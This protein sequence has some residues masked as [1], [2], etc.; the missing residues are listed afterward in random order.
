MCVGVRV[1]V[2]NVYVYTGNNTVYNYMV[3]ILSARVYSVCTYF[4]NNNIIFNACVYYIF[5]AC[6]YTLTTKIARPPLQL[7]VVV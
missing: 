2:Y 7:I 6:R 3:M 4:Y 5:I 1:C